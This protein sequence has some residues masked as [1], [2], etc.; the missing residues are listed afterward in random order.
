MTIADI[1]ITHEDN[2]KNGRYVA[3][4]GDGPEAEMTWQR[5][6]ETTIIIDHTLVPDAY[7]GQGVA[8]KLVERGIADARA[9][10]TKIVPVCSY[11]VAQ[12]KRHPEWADLLAK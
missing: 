5:R 12:F 4:L 7:R 10:G 1:D 8:Q 6:D 11:V 3:R 2:G 9:S